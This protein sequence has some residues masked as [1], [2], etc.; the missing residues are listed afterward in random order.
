MEELAVVKDSALLAGAAGSVGK[1]KPVTF[2]PTLS[3]L[4]L[5]LCTLAQAVTLSG[6]D[7]DTAIAEFE[8]AAG[9]VIQ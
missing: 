3:D 6:K 2:I 9:N 1:V 5:E 8:T 4:N 7:V